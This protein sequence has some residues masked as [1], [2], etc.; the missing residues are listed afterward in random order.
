M[1]EVERNNNFCSDRSFLYFFALVEAKIRLLKEVTS[2]LTFFQLIWSQ[3]L[4][5]ANFSSVVV[6]ICGL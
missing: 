2:E 1:F 4:I 3:E 6:E 5:E